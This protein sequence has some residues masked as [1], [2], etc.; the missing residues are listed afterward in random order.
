MFGLKINDRLQPGI[1]FQALEGGERLILNFSL[2][3]PI[4]V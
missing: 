4:K 3:L 1:D 2:S